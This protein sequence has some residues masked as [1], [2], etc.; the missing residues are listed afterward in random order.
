MQSRI[1]CSPPWCLPDMHGGVPTRVFGGHR[2]CVSRTNGTHF[3]IKS[4]VQDCSLC[5]PA[6]GRS[7][8]HTKYIQNHGSC[9]SPLLLWPYLCW[10]T[11]IYTRFGLLVAWYIRQ[12]YAKQKYEMEPVHV[13]LEWNVDHI[14]TMLQRSTSV[15]Q[16][17]F[18]TTCSQHAL[19]IL[20]MIW[21]FRGYKG[22]SDNSL[23]YTT[24][25]IMDPLK[26][27]EAWFY[28]P[29]CKQFPHRRF[30]VTLLLFC[31]LYLGI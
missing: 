27:F 22:I 9:V 21:T 4:F 11:Y 2:C 25:L 24:A 19:A 10:H 17:C 23:T 7:Q 31:V 29:G 18:T 26:P 14:P 30:L 1:L 5:N 20:P 3:E 16:E 6:P 12:N 28:D 13:D 8:S 15:I